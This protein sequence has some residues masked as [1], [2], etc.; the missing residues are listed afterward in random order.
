M[1]REGGRE[2]AWLQQERQQESRVGSRGLEDRCLREGGE[3]WEGGEGGER[4]EEGE[5]GGRVG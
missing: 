3:G 1:R 5:R 4:G 2:V